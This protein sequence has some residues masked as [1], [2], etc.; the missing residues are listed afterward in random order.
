MPLVYLLKEIETDDF[1]LKQSMNNHVK[2]QVNISDTY[3]KV[4]K[5]IKNKNANFYT[6]QPK[7]SLLH[8]TITLYYRPN[9]LNTSQF[10]WTSNLLGKNIYVTGI[11]ENQAMLAIPRHCSQ[12]KEFSC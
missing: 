12:C 4:T 10:T 11:V 5:A 7:E 1:T 2:V 9:L 3:R 6:Y 8:S